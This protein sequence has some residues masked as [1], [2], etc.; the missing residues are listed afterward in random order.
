MSSKPNLTNQSPILTKEMRLQ[1]ESQSIKRANAL[2]E[3]QLRKEVQQR[4]EIEEKLHKRSRELNQ[5]NAKLAKA[6][7][8][9]DE[10]LANMSHELRTPLNAIL[11]KTEIL[12]EGIHG[13]ITEKQAASLQVIE[14]SGRHLLKLIND[15]L[16]L[17]KIEAGKVQLDIQPVS[18]AHL[19]ERALQF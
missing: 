18:L 10:F 15:I 7:R 16:D 13:T 3:K 1:Q 17:A 9:K 5:F 19:S 4:K 11:G 8:T 2:L 14:E 6:L 12:S